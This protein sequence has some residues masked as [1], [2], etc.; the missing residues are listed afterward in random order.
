MNISIDRYK[1]LFR[2]LSNLGF[3]QTYASGTRQGAIFRGSKQIVGLKSFDRIFAYRELDSSPSNHLSIF[4]TLQ[5]EVA[6][7]YNLMFNE[8]EC[9]KQAQQDERYK[10]VTQEQ[11]IQESTI[12]ISNNL[13]VCYLDDYRK[14]LLL[15]NKY[16]LLFLSSY[17]HL[18]ASLLI[19]EQLSFVDNKEIDYLKDSFRSCLKKRFTNIAYFWSEVEIMANGIRDFVLKALEF[20]QYEIESDN[21]Y[22]SIVPTQP[23][24]LGSYDV[25]IFVKCVKVENELVHN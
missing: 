9:S 11:H 25:S 20:N 7:N 5:N 3:V 21:F 1:T 8:E 17:A 6:Q 14:Q 16:D 22:V 15:L 13:D 2:K 18:Y 19:R 23:I 12:T 4:M 10:K 24:T